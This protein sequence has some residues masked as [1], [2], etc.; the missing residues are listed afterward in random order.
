MSAS[1]TITD[2]GK[3]SLEDFAKAFGLMTGETTAATQSQIAML[4]ATGRSDE[5]IK[6]LMQ[7]AQGMA[8][9][10]IGSMQSNLQQLNM[11]FE[12]S[13]GKLGRYSSEVKGL[14]KEQ[15]E[16]GDAVDIL[17][18]KYGDFSG[19]LA[20]STAVSIADQKNQWDELKGVLGEFF[21]SGIKPIRDI[22][23]EVIQFL[24]DHKAIVIGVIE[25]IGTAIGIIITL[26]NPILGG[27]AL[28]GVA[29]FS[30]QNAVG[31][32]KMLWL[33][34]E[35]VAL[36]VVKNIM[37]VVSA[38]DNAVISGINL[39]L[40][41]YNKVS[42]LV[43][44]KPIKLLDPVDITTAVGITGA[45]K[46]V[47]AQ[48]EATAE[49]N[50]KLA[51]SH[52]TVATAALGQ[53]DAEKAAA[54]ADAKVQKELSEA[55]QKYRK[56]ADDAYLKQIESEVA[57]S[58][59]QT[60][61]ILKQKEKESK[62]EIKYESEW[63]DKAAASAKKVAESKKD[64]SKQSIADQ[65]AAIDKQEDAEEKRA[66]KSIKDTTKLE[67][68]LEN[69]RK[70]YQN[71][72]D[73]LVED[74]KKKE[75]EAGKTLG[76]AWANYFDNLKPM[77]TNWNS[78]V[79]TMASTM[80]SV[81]SRAFETIGASLVNGKADWKDFGVMALGALSKILE[82]LGKQLAALAAVSLMHLNWVG[83]ALASAG[84]AAAY[85]AA[86]AISA[87]ADSLAV[88]G[89]DYSQA[90]YYTVGE[91]GPETVYLPQGSKVANASET[92]SNIGRGSSGSSNKNI[93]FTINAGQNLSAAQIA[94]ELKH[95]SKQMAFAGIL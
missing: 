78:T 82:A 54:E 13:S 75:L 68:T 93:S 71:Q 67:E 10:G 27:I 19:L 40:T 70:T 18:K 85:V 90:G 77:A 50:K 64:Y 3:K 11:T 2:E 80:S 9:E 41:A 22:I 20:G 60:E 33:E 34:T 73:D 81:M 52:K 87:Y 21:E 16:N 95:T 37:D 31:G 47:D 72:K 57:A 49:A 59:K 46:S 45:L 56:Q 4:A 91:L 65:L 63:A 88:T 14:S 23:T 38:M 74:S 43:G 39:V 55:E 66:A 42:G 89:T 62:E 94:R 53:S 76:T 51:E 17:N 15:L 8:N 35:K 86:G 6:K 44:G 28:V 30:L 26:F 7:T 5:Q 84:A 29:I 92:A 61:E 25:G 36:L 32:W 1:S 24:A 69:I 58:A 12:G 79:S 83:A 48:I